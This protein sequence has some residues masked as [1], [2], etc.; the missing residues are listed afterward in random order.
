M[1]LDFNRSLLIHT[2][3]VVPDIRALAALA[4][5]KPSEYVNREIDI[6]GDEL[7]GPQIAG[8]LGRVLERDIVYQQTPIEQIQVFREEYA[9][10]GRGVQRKRVRSRYPGVEKGPFRSHDIREMG[11]KKQ[12]RHV[13][14]ISV[15]I[16]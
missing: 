12:V 4:F 13:D 14:G 8:I 5:K 2:L 6:A 15:C 11:T 16:P 7:T 3:I 9:L 10:I 1:V